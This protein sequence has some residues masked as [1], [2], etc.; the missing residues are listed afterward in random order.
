MS[1][2]RQ[3]RQTV[4]RD[5]AEKIAF[6]R[7][8]PQWRFFGKC[9]PQGHPDGKWQNQVKRSGKGLIRSLKFARSSH[10]V[11]L[12]SLK[13]PKAVYETRGECLGLPVDC[14]FLIGWPRFL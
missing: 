1:E 4:E 8:S 13:M 9:I 12:K 6:S 10:E 11:A 2:V 3:I 7:F 5:S 14:L